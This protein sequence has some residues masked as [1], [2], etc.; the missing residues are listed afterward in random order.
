MKD[1]IRMLAIERCKLRRSKMWLVIILLTLLPVIYGY[2]IYSII[3]V[4]QYGYD[5]ENHWYMYTVMVFLFYG[6]ICLPVAVAIVARAL[7]GFEKEAGNWEKISLSPIT[8]THVFL[9]KWAWIATLACLTQLWTFSLIIAGGYI[10]GIQDQLP[11]LTLFIPAFLLGTFGAS[12]AGTLQFYLY[13]RFNT[14]SALSL[15]ILMSIPVF[16][17]FSNESG[18]L[19]PYLYPWALPI[20]GMTAATSGGI[21]LL[22]FI[23]VCLLLSLGLSYLSIRLIKQGVPANG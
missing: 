8:A 4:N 22:T 12:A 9:S 19:L 10:A 6:T 21:Q 5:T 16:L 20:L 18:S 13:L 17:I 14:S 3:M 23:S 7:H 2:V 15:N 11:V 1:W